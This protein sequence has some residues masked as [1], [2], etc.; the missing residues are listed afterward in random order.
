MLPKGTDENSNSDMAACYVTLDELAEQH[1]CAA[2]VVHHTS[3]GSQS[4]KSV[5]D[6]G[7]GA[8]AQSRSADVHIVLRDHEDH[9]SVV[10]QAIVRSQRPIKPTCLTFDYPLW[11]LAPDL[12]PDRVAVLNKKPSP[13]FD[14]FLATIP[15]DLQ[16]KNDVLAQSKAKLGCSKPDLL[17]LLHKATSDGF[18]EVVKPINKTLPHT[19]RRI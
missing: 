11:R 19:I 4:A 3:K 8:G 16:S 17:A 7:A 5:S 12:S 15:T 10:L 2:V 18:V 14:E 9:N 13:T 6:M 1:N